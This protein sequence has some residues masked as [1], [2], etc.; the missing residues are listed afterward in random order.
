MKSNISED[1]QLASIMRFRAGLNLSTSVN[2]FKNIDY[3]LN[4]GNYHIVFDPNTNMMLAYILWADVAEETLER[5]MDYNIKPIYLH[6]WKEGSIGLILDFAVS[7]IYKFNV[8]EL[9]PDTFEDAR[10]IYKKSGRSYNLGEVIK[11][12]KNKIK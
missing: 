7:S 10:F 6:E 8:L 1:T 11:A 12:L 9:L 5:Y 3:S 4:Q 2:E